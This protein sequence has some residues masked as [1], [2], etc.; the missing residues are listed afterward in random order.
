M[1]AALLSCITA[2]YTAHPAH[3]AL[4]CPGWAFLTLLSSPH[5]ASDLVTSYHIEKAEFGQQAKCYLILAFL[6]LTARGKF[7]FLGHLSISLMN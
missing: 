2:G 5:T 7:V 1:C 3:P 6:I 4:G